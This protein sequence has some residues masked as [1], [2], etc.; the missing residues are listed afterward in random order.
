MKRKEDSEVAEVNAE[1]VLIF[2]HGAGGSGDE[3]SSFL[4][5]IVPSKTKLILP[6][7][8]K[9]TVAMFGWMEMNS[10]FNMYSTYASNI[11]EV[12]N[13]TIMIHSLMYQEMKRGI[14]AEQ[15]LLGGF[16]QGAAL[17]LYSSLTFP[18][19]LGGTLVLSGWLLAPWE[20]PNDV[21]MLPNYHSPLLQ[22][23][24]E[25]DMMVGLLHKLC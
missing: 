1:H 3:W 8:P 6:T 9:A 17:A 5:D 22:C 10:W 13:A 24:G 19:K 16:S 14:P 25:R 12:K 21:Q 18:F 23:H 20:F 7:A 4:Q 2:L 11:P 15:I